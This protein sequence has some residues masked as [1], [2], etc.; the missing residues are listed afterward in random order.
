MLKNCK[1]YSRV[2]HLIIIILKKTIRTEATSDGLIIK[3]PFTENSS[4]LF[5]SCSENK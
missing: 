4:G 3:N 2:I 5:N 1:Y